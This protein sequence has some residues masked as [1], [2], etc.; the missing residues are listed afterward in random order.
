MSGFNEIKITILNG[1]NEV[2]IQDE[3]PRLIEYQ[4]FY[5]YEE[6]NCWSEAYIYDICR[7]FPEDVYSTKIDTLDAYG[8]YE[9]LLTITS[10]YKRSYTFTT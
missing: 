7:M 10:E 9:G 8:I 3:T 1:R 2:V 4:K 5:D 6:F